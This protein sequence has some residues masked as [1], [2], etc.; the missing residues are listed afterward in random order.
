MLKGLWTWYIYCRSSWLLVYDLNVNHWTNSQSGNG[1]F[2]LRYS[3]HTLSYF[4]Y[5]FSSY[6]PPMLGK[7][8]R[9]VE[10]YFQT[11]DASQG[12]VP[13]HQ[14]SCHSFYTA[15]IWRASII[16]SDK[17]DYSHF[18][19]LHVTEELSYTFLYSSIMGHTTTLRFI[20][21]PNMPL[22]I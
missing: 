6:F 15:S 18:C 5:L 9:S 13:R 21:I 19:T 4:F 7:L 3:K 11:V 14:H 16:S 10:F 17:A 12:I 2:P 1:I 8:M 20:V 22:S